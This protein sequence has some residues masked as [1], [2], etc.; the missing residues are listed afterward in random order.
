MDNE[1]LLRVLILDESLNDADTLAS[2]LRNAGFAL[3]PAGAQND[4]QLRE[5]VRNQSL[6]LVLCSVENTEPSLLHVH[7]ALK[8]LDR[9][10]PVIAVTGDYDAEILVEVMRDGAADLVIK[11]NPEHLR[12]VVERELAARDAR[13]R[14]RQS[15]RAMRESEKRCRALLDSSRDAITYVHDGMHIYAN[16]VYLEL[17]GFDDLEDIEGMPIMDMVAPDDHSKF[18]DFIRAFSQGKLQ[19]NEL[20]VL[21]LRGDASTFNAVMEFSPASIDGEPCTQII[22][23]NQ[24]MDKELEKKIKYLSK[25]DLLTGL[26]NRQYFTEELEQAI[27]DA[28]GGTSSSAVLY[29]EPD[30]FKDVKGKVG[31][32]GADLV[33]SDLAGLIRGQLGETCMAA[34]FG[35]QVFTVLC[36]DTDGNVA[37]VMAAQLRSA[38]EGHIS[39]VDG[40]SITLT[41]SIG[42]ALVGEAATDAQ[43]VLARAD[44]ACEMA[45]KK[46]GNTVHLHNP[47]ADEKAGRERDQEWI[48]KIRTALEQNRFQLVYQPIA[49]LHGETQEKYEVLL[50]L[51]ADDGSVVLPGQFLPIAEHHNLINAVDRWVIGRALSV[52]AE[53]RQG[54]HDTTFFVKLSAKSALDETLLPWISEQLKKT[55]LQG[56]S[57]VFEIS[58]S[59]AVTH[60]KQVKAFAAGLKE[61]HC[62]FSLEHFGNGMNSFQLLKHIP[63]DYLKIDGSFMHNLASNQENQAMVKSI[64]EMAHSMGKTTI[65]EFVEDANSLAVLWQSG[66]N[67]IQG[68]FLQEPGEEMNYDFQ[69]EEG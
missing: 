16:P 26:H 50:R 67:Y 4:E 66:V 57:L 38:I 36:R 6:D 15:D 2:H 68:H 18:K 17:F 52:L 44:L 35:D 54:G 12:L 25:Q 23:R 9:D 40:Q 56:N 41:A 45:R 64:T 48:Q 58:E 34:R 65:A 19:E 21:G 20:E 10:I 3:R 62:G 33:L 24:S 13:R 1:N 51:R 7:Q 49:S 60:L 37:E 69:G 27:A 30:A 39:D 55:R 46:G 31:M 61:L 28:A 43:E 32:S 42:I 29:I 47:V 59:S 22:I 53:R 63:A 5:A 8:S 11:D 14:M